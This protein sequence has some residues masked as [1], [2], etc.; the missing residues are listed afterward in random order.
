MQE[1]GRFIRY[2]LV[3]K[4]GCENT[5]IHKNTQWKLL[6]RPEMKVIFVSLG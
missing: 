3:G 1:T 5:E 2:G 4:N 6:G